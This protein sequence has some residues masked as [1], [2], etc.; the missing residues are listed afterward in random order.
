MRDIIKGFQLAWSL[1]IQK[2]IV[3][4][5]SRAA[6]AILVRNLNFCLISKF[7]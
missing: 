6:I 1:G 3:H 7:R 5:D 4:L 2:L